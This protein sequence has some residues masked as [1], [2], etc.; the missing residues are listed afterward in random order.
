MKRNPWID[1]LDRLR[2][3]RSDIPDFGRL[4]PNQALETDRE[5]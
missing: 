1:A 5:S 3:E 4:L 2:D